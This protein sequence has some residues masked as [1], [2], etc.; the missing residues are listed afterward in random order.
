M[1]VFATTDINKIITDENENHCII[2]NKVLDDEVETSTQM[3]DEEVQLSQQFNQEEKDACHWMSRRT[4][5]YAIAL[6]G[7]FVI[8][9]DSVSFS[10][11]F[12][13]IFTNRKES[14]D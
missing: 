1:H 4:Y 10:L 14:G 2:V 7:V 3:L 13:F 11:L 8:S 5:G 12:F 9:P 6:G